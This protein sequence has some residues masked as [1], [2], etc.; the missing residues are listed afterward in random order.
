M[1]SSWYGEHRRQLEQQQSRVL[2]IFVIDPIS[3]SEICELG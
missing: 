2:Y 3:M 1:C